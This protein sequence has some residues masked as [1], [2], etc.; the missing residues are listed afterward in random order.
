[1]TELDVMKTIFLSTSQFWASYMRMCVI[2]WVQNLSNNIRN[3]VVTYIK[4]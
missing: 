3:I 2:T 4:H 1:M